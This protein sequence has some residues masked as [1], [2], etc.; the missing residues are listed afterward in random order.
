MLHRCYGLAPRSRLIEKGGKKYLF[1]AHP[2][3][4][5][6]VNDAAWL[7]LSALDG[8]TPLHELVE[9]P[10]RELIR[11]LDHKA[12]LGLLHSS[13]QAVRADAGAEWPEVAVI[14]PAYG[15]LPG[16]RRCLEALG[17]LNYPRDSM[18]VTVVDDATPSSL[19]DELR[20]VDFAGLTTSWLHLIDNMG[21]ATARNAGAGLFAVPVPERASMPHPSAQLLAFV[22]SDC[23]P[24]PGWLEVLVPWL[25]DEHVGAVGGGVEG[26]SDKGLLAN[27]EAACSSLNMGQKAGAAGI[28]GGRIPYLPSCN[29]IVKRAVFDELSGFRDGMRLG[30]DVDFCWRLT[31]AGHGLF[32]HPPGT[33]HHGYRSRVLPFLNRKRAYAFSESWLRRHHRPHFSAWGRAPFLAALLVAGAALIAA[34]FRLLGAVP[35]PLL[36]ARMAGLMRSGGVLR[37]AGLRAAAGAV[38]RGSAAEWLY[39]CRWVLR[40]TLVLWLPLVG[41]LPRLGPLAG[42]LLVMGLLGEWL[43][44]GRRIGLWVFAVGF[45]GECLAYSLGRI[46]GEAHALWRRV[47]GRD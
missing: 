47:R 22:D 20:G 25:E 2:L 17:G 37:M 13:Y 46:Q 36:L 12:D 43:A 23:V 45:V 1:C 14:V 38:L 4:R 16:L 31:A 40:H 41:A 27:Y 33:V 28:P 29:L 15:D 21:P 3:R 10:T 44:R 5:F 18:S 19:L 9:A 11:F 35:I 39:Q 26:L 6:A 7:V 24:S 34:E 42:A 32:Y 8:A 30:E